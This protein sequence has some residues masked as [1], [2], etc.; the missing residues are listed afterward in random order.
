MDLLLLGGTGFLG[1]Q[2]AES[3][4]SRGHRVTLFHRRPTEALAAAEHLLGDRTVGLDALGDR[5]WDAVIDVWA[6]DPALVAA[7]ARELAPRAGAYAFISS[8]SVF[9][10]ESRPGSNEKSAIR[11]APDPAKSDAENYGARKAE[12]E[13]RV[14]DATD[15]AA[16]VVRPGLIVGP[17]DPTDR[18]TYWPVRMARGGTALAPGDGDNPAQ[19]IDVRDLAQWIL[20]LLENRVVGTYGA[21]GPAEAMTLGEMIGRVR[22]AVGSDTQLRWVSEEYLLA[23]GVAPW[24]DLPV[25]IPVGDEQAGMLAR[26]CRK[27]I[28]AGLSFRDLE[29]T[30]RD[31]LA[32]HRTRPEGER[33]WLSEVRERELLA[34]A[35]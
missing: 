26:D 32:W 14:Q 7:A 11:G 5:H 10:D 4:L 19:V 22:E 2:L 9:A 23:H 29:D 6:N 28:A 1:P 16:L 30:A 8:M 34:A 21:S 27:A 15:G 13:R 24:I 20:T 33:P 25:W 31:T 12:G 17:G 18:F 3:A 35:P